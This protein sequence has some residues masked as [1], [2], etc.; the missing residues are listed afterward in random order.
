MKISTNLVI[1]IMCLAGLSCQNNSRND[2]KTSFE[3]Q[4]IDS[5]ESAR[6]AIVGVWT[7][8]EP[9]QTMVQMAVGWNKYVFYL[10]GT[11]EYYRAQPSDDDWGKPKKGKWKVFSDKYINTG[12]RYYGIDWENYRPLIFVDAQTVKLIDTNGSL[13]ATLRK[14]DDFPFS[15]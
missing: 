4:L 5:E 7:S 15:D 6:K 3:I 1:L 14:G 9:L 10:N 13:L 12:K 2:G 8:S 11:F